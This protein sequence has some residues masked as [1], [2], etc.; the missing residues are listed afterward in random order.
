MTIAKSILILLVFSLS[1]RVNSQS[2]GLR[3]ITGLW[4]LDKYEAFDSTTGKWKDAPNRIGYFGY[5]LYD[6]SAHVAVQLFPPGFRTINVSTSMDSLNTDQLREMATAQSRCFIYFA[7]YKIWERQNLIEHYIFS[8][9]H[10]NE[11]GTT[12]KRNFEFK[13]DTLV[14]TANELIGGFKTRLRWI[15]KANTK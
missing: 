14:L 15:R 9:N 13:G 2:S 8:S 1:H 5:I 6:G 7:N 4:Q 12:V 11:I 3:R 10:P